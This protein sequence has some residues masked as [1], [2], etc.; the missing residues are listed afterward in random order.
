M[1]QQ[2]QEATASPLLPCNQR[3]FPLAGR[4]ALKGFYIYQEGVKNRSLNSGMDELLAR[5]KL[6]A[7]PAV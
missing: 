2:P 5:F 4:K 3:P 7:N 6:S 1:S